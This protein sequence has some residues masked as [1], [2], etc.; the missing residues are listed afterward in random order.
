MEALRTAPPRREWL[1]LGLVVLCSVLLS[2]KYFPGVENSQYYAGLSLQTIH[3][4][5]MAND[6]AHGR[7]LSLTDTPYKLTIYYLFPKLLGE[8][9]LD[10]RFIL[11][12]YI[13]MVAACFLAVDRMARLF[14]L[15]GLAERSAVL[16]L[17]MKDHQ[18]IANKVIFAHDPDFH[19]SG[20]SLPISLWLLYLGLAGRSVWAVI[21]LSLVLAAVS[22]QVTPFNALLALGL[23]AVGVAQG[24]RRLVLALLAGGILCLGLVMVVTAPPAADR[25]ELWSMLTTRWFKNM[26]DPFNIIRDGMLLTSVWNVA[27]V[28]LCLGVILWRGETAAPL[29][30]LRVAGIATLGL[31]AWAGLYVH[32]APPSLQFPQLLLFPYAREL[33]AV[34][35]VL[36]VGLAALAFRWAE[37]RGGGLAGVGA[38]LVI[39][40][41]VV[42]GPGN[43]PMW[44]GLLAA[45]LAAAGGFQVVRGGAGS[46][47]GWPAQRTMI[48]T[49][50]VLSM[51]VASAVAVRQRLP[52]LVHLARTGIHGGSSQAK[53]LGVAEYLRSHTPVGSV[54]FSFQYAENFDPAKPRMDVRR[55]VA[56]RSGRAVAFPF[57]LERGLKLP[58]FRY[59][60]GQRDNAFALALAWYLG[61]RAEVEERLEQVSPRIDYML[62]PN[63]LVDRVAGPG[64]PFQ[65]ETSIRDWTVLR[66]V[67]GQGTMLPQGKP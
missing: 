59:A 49:A 31:W 55:D 24:K 14:G 39:A 8:I 56:S 13:L 54:L 6:P 9:W 65:V 53:W 43:Y 3:P 44:L 50:L 15:T 20:I 48:A 1:I 63:E 35:A 27:F 34:Q 40:A 47:A 22:L 5:L 19:H 26:A 42:A 64:F 52:D 62:V 28:A 18:L 57:L 37:K 16:L 2:V 10:D 33:Q 60:Q 46:L 17:F 51:G 36:F 66:R 38:I 30:R 58:E 25:P 4:E 29:R 23:L 61:D 32:Y 21:A 7:P 12:L 45:G 11:P 67:A 41:L